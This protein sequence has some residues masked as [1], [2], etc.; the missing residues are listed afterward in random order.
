MSRKRL[1][2]AISAGLP[3]EDS[4]PF[5]CSETSKDII[6]DDEPRAHGTG[7][8]DGV[9]RPSTPQDAMI[10]SLLLSFLRIFGSASALP[11]R[12]NGLDIWHGY[13]ARPALIEL[14]VLASRFRIDFPH[15]HES[16]R[17]DALT[18]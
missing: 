14:G 3:P 6:A 17:L 5:P 4:R 2:N 9:E 8:N 11:P 7:D 12:A 15:F 16:R 10:S 18:Q 1:F 13:L